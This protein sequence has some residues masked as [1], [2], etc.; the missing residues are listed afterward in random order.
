MRVCRLPTV[1][2]SG[3]GFCLLNASCVC[4][5]HVVSGACALSTVRAKRRCALDAG[6]SGKVKMSHF[7]E[8]SCELGSRPMA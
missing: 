2:C 4:L 3:L 6:V 8:D 1:L 5:V 7:T